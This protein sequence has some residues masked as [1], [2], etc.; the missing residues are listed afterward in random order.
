MC[1]FFFFM[2]HKMELAVKKSAEELIPLPTGYGK[3]VIYAVLPLVYLAVCNEYI[4]LVVL[5]IA[6]FL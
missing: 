1:R 3:F 6:R 4:V 2:K 5:H